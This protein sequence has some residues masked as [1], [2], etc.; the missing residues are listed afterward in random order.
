MPSTA[1]RREAWRNSPR[2][3]HVARVV[4]PEGLQ[5]SLKGHS[6]ANPPPSR[7]DA[8]TEKGHVTNH[9]GAEAGKNDNAAPSAKGKD[10]MAASSVPIVLSILAEEDSYGYAS[11]SAFAT[12]PKGVW[13]GLTGCSTQFSTDSSGSATSRCAG[14]PRRAAVAVSITASRRGGG[15]S[16]PRIGASGRRWMRRCGA[17]GKRS[18]PA[19][20]VSQ[21]H[22]RHGPREP[23]R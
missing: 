10:L 19:W 16:S 5:Y 12:R 1:D 4:G 3:R 20:P 18:R 15:L 23:E 2:M 17:S 6:P 7:L 21:R 22:P 8:P 9:I 11:S 13:S 14:K